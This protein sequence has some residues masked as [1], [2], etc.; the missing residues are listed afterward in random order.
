MNLKIFII[1]NLIFSLFYALTLAENERNDCID[2]EDIDGIYSCKTNENGELEY[3]KFKNEDYYTED[4][5]QELLSFDTI[6]TLIYHYE[7]EAIWDCMITVEVETESITGDID[8]YVDKRIEEI[9]KE[10]ENRENTLGF[11]RAHNIYPIEIKKNM[12]N[13]EEL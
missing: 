4:F 5:V 2:I 3:L 6:K 9:Y 7:R 13:L 11:K 12:D 8:E 1:R 10:I